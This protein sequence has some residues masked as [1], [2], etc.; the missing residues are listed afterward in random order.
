VR[1]KDLAH[2]DGEIRE[3]AGSRPLATMETAMLAV[4][5]SLQRQDDDALVASRERIDDPVVCD[6]RL[7]ILAPLLLRFP[8]PMIGTHDFYNQVSASAELIL[9]P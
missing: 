6:V 5:G 4:A 3:E 9:R 8:L 7:R 1:V 2:A